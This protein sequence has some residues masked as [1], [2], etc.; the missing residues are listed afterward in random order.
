MLDN[1][2]SQLCACA[3]SSEKLQSFFLWDP[4]PMNATPI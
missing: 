3:E 1:R 2:A 4:G